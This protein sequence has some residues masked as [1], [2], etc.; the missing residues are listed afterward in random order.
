MCAHLQ[1][2]KVLEQDLRVVKSSPECRTG[3]NEPDNETKQLPIR[4]C[5]LIPADLSA[6]KV[7]QAAHAVVDFLVYLP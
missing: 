7:V 4:V 2:R 6:I 3:D 1:P 5:L